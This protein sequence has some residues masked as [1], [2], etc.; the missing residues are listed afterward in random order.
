MH[1]SPTMGDSM[2]QDLTDIT[3]VLDRSGSM[4]RV[5]TD[6]IGGYNAFIG[7]Q[8]KAPGIANVTTILF[9]DKY[10]VLHSGIP[11]KDVPIMTDDVFVPRGMT[12]LYDAVGKSINVAGERFSKM[13]EEQRPS[14]VIF[15]ILTDGQE[16]AS[17]EFTNTNI[18]DMIELQK[19]TYHWDFVFLGANINA[20]VVGASMGINAGNSMTFAANSVGTQAAFM[21]MATNMT[22]YREVK[23]RQGPMRDYFSTVDRQAQTKAG[24]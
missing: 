8:K 14:K 6:T 4:Q 24:A 13:T 5:L 21:S 20:E 18:R 12:A 3:L 23:D 7:T 19:T 2:N 1:G 16:N 11:V 9:D 15:V 17:Q 10:D 22:S